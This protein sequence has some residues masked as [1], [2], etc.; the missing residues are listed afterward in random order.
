MKRTPPSQLPSLR[1]AALIVKDLPDE[2]LVYDKVSDKAHCLNQTAA[3]VWRAC[4][5]QR[6]PAEIA[7][8][9]TS[10]L[11][12]NVSEDTVLLALEQ[13]EKINLLERYETAPASFAGLSRRQ[14]VRTLGLA[15]AVALPVV[16]TIIAPTPV[17]A[18]TCKH[19]NSS[20][21]TGADC[22]SGVCAGSPPKCIGG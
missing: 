9:L 3:L 22:C 14:M 13:L 7:R 19:N 4:N 8:K 6:M 20:C 17:Q 16:T 10:E 12:A 11:D 2:V 18:G 1:A 21:S 15:A 5:G